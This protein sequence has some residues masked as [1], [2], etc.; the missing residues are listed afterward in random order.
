MDSNINNE[1]AAVINRLRDDMIH[2]LTELVR[3]P[4]VVGNEGEAQAFMRQLYGGL[5]LELHRVEA[6]KKKLRD[7]PAYVESG[8]SFEGRPNIIGLLKGDPQ[9]KSIILNGHVDVVSP[10]PID[11]WQHDPWGVK[12][13]VIGFT[14]G[15]PWT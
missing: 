9:K 4:S 6:D 1:L 12:S 10:E 13:K 7:H 2:T 8:L 11:Q 5:G 14:A 15:A 3:I